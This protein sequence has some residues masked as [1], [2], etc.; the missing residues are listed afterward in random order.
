VEAVHDAVRDAI[1]PPSAA[2]HDTRH[3]T[4][5]TNIT[6][7]REKD[8]DSLWTKVTSGRAKDVV[9]ARRAKSLGRRACDDA[10][11]PCSQ[12]GRTH[13]R[14]CPYSASATAQKGARLPLRPKPF[15]T[16]FGRTNNTSLAA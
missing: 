16:G 11:G 4:L 15:E 8:M 2:T 3:R 9:R 6:S 14:R 1:R 12:R 7:G 13:G 5:T 10:I